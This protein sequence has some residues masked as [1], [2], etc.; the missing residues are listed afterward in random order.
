MSSARA[1]L[2]SC[3]L[4]PLLGLAQSRDINETLI[5]VPVSVQDREGRTIS[6]DIPV[7]LFRPD[8]PG[9]F[10]LVVISHGRAST[11][12]KR[13]EPAIQ[14][15]ESA[16]R[17]FVRKGFA[18][19]VPTRLGYGETLALG[20]PERSR[21]SCGNAEYADAMAAGAR[22]V[23]TVVEH[24]RQ[25]PWVDAQRL[26]LVGQSVG[27][28]VSTAANASRPAGLL[29]AIN[30][31]G[32]S[33][34]NPETHPGVPCAGANVGKAYA[35]FGSTAQAPMLWVYTENDRYFDPA[36]SRAWHAAYT[37]AGGQAEYRLLPAFG[38]DGH[39]LFAR[40]NDIWQPV[41]D[42]F[43]ARFGFTRPGSLQ[44]EWSDYA[45]LTDSQR[46][47]Y[48]SAQAIREGYA[49][50]LAA[51]SPRAFAIAPQGG[52]GWASG[53]D[54]LSRALAN[55]QQHDKT[56]CRLYAVDDTVVWR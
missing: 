35:N 27:G 33:G 6:G 8:G 3:L 12:A 10:P 14:R 42:E 50:F 15:Q 7:S 36:H 53:D 31:A 9:P 13:A 55:C 20:D 38:E 1:F 51:K 32:G 49:K 4:W 24:L 28:F 18:V 56:R 48:L 41:V 37:G 52:W 26:V 39:T 11:P 34:G 17:F 44:A 22:Q 30:F 16:A 43:L 19:A 23:V 5:R 21:G 47:P 54:S 40:G 46:I 29:A 45:A 2:L 25:Q